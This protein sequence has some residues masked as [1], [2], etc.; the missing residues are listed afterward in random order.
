MTGRIHGRA[1]DMRQAHASGAA[2]APSVGAVVECHASRVLLHPALVRRLSPHSGVR[3]IA[4][5]VLKCTMAGFDFGAAAELYP[6]RGRGVS[7]IVTYL[8]F[9]TAAEAIRY[10]IEELAPALLAGTILEIEERRY[11][12]GQIQALYDSKEFPLTRRI[13]VKKIHSRRV[14]PPRN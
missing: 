12:K 3:R 5:A 9:E 14:R 4:S 10:A 11:H 7:S 2:I 8:R 13:V 1:R 6:T